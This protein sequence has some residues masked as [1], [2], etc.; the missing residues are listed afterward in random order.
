MTDPILVEPSERFDHAG[1]DSEDPGDFEFHAAPDVVGEELLRLLDAD[2]DSG[3]ELVTCAAFLRPGG[4]WGGASAPVDRAQA[5]GSRQGLR[6]TSRK[7]NKLSPGSDHH[8][9]QRASD[10]VD[11][12]GPP[13]A[14]DRTARRI[15][16]ALGVPNWRGGLL[17]RQCAGVRAQL[18]WKYPD[19]Y[20]H[21]HFGCRRE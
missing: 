6:V 13:G 5:I 2:E 12:A 18:I 9:S 7:R 4:A 20:D 8:I 1:D 14:M 15:A 21:V 19:H 16:A 10:A 3:F 17:Q 11:L